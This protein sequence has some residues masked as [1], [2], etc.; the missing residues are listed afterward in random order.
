MIIDL[1]REDQYLPATVAIRR[2]NAASQPLIPAVTRALQAVSMEYDTNGAYDLW[3]DIH[4]S[5]EEALQKIEEQY[6]RIYWY[7]SEEIRILLEDTEV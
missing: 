1:L 4:T 7:I 5:T 2:M 6:P 3:F